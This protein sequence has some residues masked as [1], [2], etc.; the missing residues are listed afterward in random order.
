MVRDIFVKR[1]A[2]WTKL[3]SCWATA[4][5]TRVFLNTC[6]TSTSGGPDGGSTGRASPLWKIFICILLQK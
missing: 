3:I 4:R 6:S 2:R 1:H 5:S